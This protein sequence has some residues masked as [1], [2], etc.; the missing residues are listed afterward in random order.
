MSTP[1]FPALRLQLIRNSLARAV[2][3]APKS[4]HITPS[5][6]S[7]KSLKINERIDCKILSHT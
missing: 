6:K 4:S 2:V 7:L 5:L 1:H 3:R